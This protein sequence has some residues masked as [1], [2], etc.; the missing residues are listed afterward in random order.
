MCPRWLF[1]V[2]SL[3]AACRFCLGQVP[4]T[5][6]AVNPEGEHDQA[7]RGGGGLDATRASGPATLD[8]KADGNSRVTVSA[9]VE[10][11]LVEVWINEQPVE[12]FA[13]VLRDGERFFATAEQFLR[14]RLT[15]PNGMPIA[16]GG[17][18][19]LPLNGAGM[20]SRLDFARQRLDITVAA[21]L[22]TPTILK[23][24]QLAVTPTR[25]GMG[26]FL[27]HDFRVER[28]FENATRV[29]GL[30]ELGLFSGLGVLTSRFAAADFLRTQHPVRLETQ[31]MHDFPERM[32]TL[33]VGDG[34]SANSPWS[35]QVYYGGVRYGSKFSTQPT[36][37]PF[38]VPSLA[39]QAA[40][41]STVDIYVNGVRTMGEPVN[42]GPFSIPNVPVITG[43][44]SINMVVTDVL[45]RQQV[46]KVGY[47]SSEQLLRP[48]LSEYTVEGGL[49]RHDFGVGSGQYSGMFLAGTYR[50]GLSDT[51]TLNLRGEVA[52]TGQAFGVGVNAGI[53]PF[54]VVSAGGAV[55]TSS[56]A[57]GELGYVQLQHAARH[58][59]FT[60]RLQLAS[61]DFHQLG[62]NRYESA[63]R[64]LS[65]TQ[66]GYAVGKWAS[67]GV[68][69]LQQEHRPCYRAGCLLSGAGNF[70]AVTGS[71][72]LQ[73]RQA[74]LGVSVIRSPGA[75]PYV[76]INLAI[77][78][79]NRKIASATTEMQGGQVRGSV[80]FTQQLP[81][82]PGYGYRVR[83]SEGPSPRIDAGV[84]LQTAVG[85]YA[86]E[87]SQY[88]GHM[89]WRLSETGSVVLL[90]NRVALSR[91]L[92]DSFA[93]VDVPEVS[94]VAVLANNQRVG[95]T[96]R[97]GLLVI[98]SLP[99][100]NRNSIALDEATVPLDRVVDLDAKTLVPMPRTGTR[101]LF[102]NKRASGALL[103]LINQEQ[104]PVPLGAVVS[105]SGDEQTYEVALRGE[106]F[107]PSMSFPAHLRVTWEGHSCGA[108][109]SAPTNQELVPT[110][111]P[112]LCKEHK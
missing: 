29:S 85:T 60:T 44:G 55:G 24:N 15:L 1:W 23:A 104:E 64:V 57:V 84:A 25:P 18:L 40:L 9:A 4:A 42:A 107:I 94:G 47:L 38:A 32:T 53:F 54:G 37:V 106:V 102:R 58:L 87:G 12:K 34:V 77:P 95:N 20:D 21:G 45:G 86:L 112:I 71:V 5:L 93:V 80:D 10:E 99:A 63:P 72:G 98:P 49:L 48:K 97:R 61:R 30:V 65:Q 89:T 73:I 3:F 78:L 66:L 8:S 39:G 88:A 92:T 100:Y 22:F 83:V 11:V 74:S 26:L 81:A 101:V 108:V 91:W 28:S 16:Y 109:V 35:R 62:M 96:S 56:G 50:R 52:D 105:I 51:L 2:L 43:Q 33:V 31:F 14:W 69:Y 46:L 103:E 41:P 7:S 27:S 59:S 67:L 70:S 17:E 6:A 76:A 90:G 68:G 79:G 110:I 82:G 75:K 36:F 13:S 19:Y 111:G